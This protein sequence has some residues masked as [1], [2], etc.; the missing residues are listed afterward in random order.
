MAKLPNIAL[1]AIVLVTL[2][3]TNEKVMLEEDLCWMGCQGLIKRL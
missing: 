1:K 3:G 2:S